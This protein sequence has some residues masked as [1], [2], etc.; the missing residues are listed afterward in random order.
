ML[1]FDIFIFSN[2]A[3]VI[4]FC[5]K[6]KKKKHGNQ[7]RGKN[8]VAKFL[9]KATNFWSNFCTMKEV[10]FFVTIFYFFIILEADEFGHFWW[11]IKFM[12]MSEKK[13][14]FHCVINLFQERRLWGVRF[15]NDNMKSIFAIIII[16]IIKNKNFHEGRLPWEYNDRVNRMWL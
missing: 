8:L 13:K 7:N 10:F 3:S 11:T 2:D 12:S 1:R 16:I 5:K 9:E 4:T 14:I 15:L 6:K